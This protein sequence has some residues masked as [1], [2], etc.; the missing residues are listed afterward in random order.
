MSHLVYRNGTYYWRR[1]LPRVVADLLGREYLWRSLRTGRVREA[2]ELARQIT[3][4]TDRIF[5][6]VTKPD[7][8]SAATVDRL[9]RQYIE[10]ALRERS[11][12]FKS[13][14]WEA[15]EDRDESLEVSI[16]VE[17]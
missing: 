11:E 2:Q 4:T 17:Y 12:D 1:R 14:T 5:S 9:L 15:I 7:G 16:G 10:E 3:A 6:A 13:V 8:P